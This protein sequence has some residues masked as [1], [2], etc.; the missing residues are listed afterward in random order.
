MK[1]QQIS[2]IFCGADGSRTR[3]Q[4]RNKY[5]FYMLIRLLIFGRWPATG[6][7]PAHYPLIFHCGNEAAPQLFP[8]HERPLIANRGTG[9]AGDVLSNTLCRMKLIYYVSI[10]QQERNYNRH[11]RFCDPDLR[12]IS[13]GSACLQYPFTLLSKPNSPINMYWLQNQKFR[14]FVFGVGVQNVLI[15]FKP[16]FFSDFGTKIINFHQSDA[17]IFFYYKY[18]IIFSNFAACKL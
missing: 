14:R 15:I 16:T 18:F 6:S 13:R 3:V 8:S 17:F 1:Q 2:A 7:L 4:T 9:F 10:R 5:A 12:D 11:L